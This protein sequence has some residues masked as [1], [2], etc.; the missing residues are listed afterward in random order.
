MTIALNGIPRH[1]ELSYSRNRRSLTIHYDY[2]LGHIESEGETL[3]PQN[4][5]RYNFPNFGIRHTVNY[6]PLDQVEN[7]QRIT[8]VVRVLKGFR[9]RTLE[10]SL[11]LD[12]E[13]FSQIACAAPFFDLRQRR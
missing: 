3:E 4:R 1:R 2:S 5:F 6:G 12:T 9:L 10:I 8:D 7:Q 13:D 11:S